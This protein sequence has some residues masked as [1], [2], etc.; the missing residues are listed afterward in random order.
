[1]AKFYEA[2]PDLV[3]KAIQASLEAKKEWEQVSLDE[4]M[5]LFLKVADLMATKYRAELN[6]TTM[7]GQ[8][9][10]VI[11]VRRMRWLPSRHQLSEHRI[12][13]RSNYGVSFNRGFGLYPTY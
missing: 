7:L 10:T 1:M 11:Q 9:K 13:N 4:R 5:K 3:A 8:S 2:T 6:A 12:Y